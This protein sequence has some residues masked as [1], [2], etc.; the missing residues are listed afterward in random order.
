VSSLVGTAALVRLALRRDRII[1]PVFIIILAVMVAAS[2]YAT[3]ELYPT[4]ASRVEATAV[5]NTATSTLAMFGPIHDE[6]SVG[7]LSTFKMGI[8]GAIAVA[9]LALIIVVRHT[10]AEEETG[11][12]EMLGATVVGRRAPL[13]AALLVAGGASLLTGIVTALTMI[14]VGMPIRGS[15]VMGFGFAGLG[16]AFAAVAAFTAQLTKSARAASGMAGGA[17]GFFYL[18]R[19]IGDASAGNGL[20]W[21]SWLSPVGW[22]QQTRPFAGD[23]WW[24]LGLLL[25]LAV[26]LS[27]LAYV[28]AARRD[29]AA[30]LLPDRPGPA[31]ASPSL[32][33]PLALAW[34]LQRGG[35]LAW[36]VTFVAAGFVVGGLTS[37]VD[38]FL[39]SPQALDFIAK[40]GGVQSISDAF[41]AVELGFMGVFLSVFGMQAAMRLRSE[42]T[43]MRAEPL[44]ATAVGRV[45][46]AL[47]HVTIAVLGTT[48]LAVFMGLSAGLTSAAQVGDIG[49][50]GRILLGALV[51]LPAV[52][53]VVGIT[54]AA[55]GM[56]PRQ[57]VI[58][59]VALVGFVLLGE[60]GALFD[61]NQAVMDISPFAHVPRIPGGEFVAAPMLW[62]TAVAAALIVA[63]LSGFRRRDL[64]GS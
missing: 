9:V 35:F 41:L 21:V 22:W 31:A 63:G 2:A 40:L 7:A 48:A 52:W 60:F 3:A 34:R 53:V 33:S 47:S 64:G 12:L 20:S 10:R 6:T 17:L 1:L 55:F 37:S 62:L 25:G 23:R 5:I 51:Q 8:M 4:V 61:L 13:T 14:A 44:L 38:D 59:W 45:T 11:R 49:Q 57:I 19:A 36:A 30:G 15:V 42:E 54:V 28:L 27:A 29:F 58:G 50:L 32:R 26:V 46:W 18:L 24:V 56:A 39:T 16:I 43:A